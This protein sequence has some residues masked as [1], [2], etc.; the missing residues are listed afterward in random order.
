MPSVQKY[1][2]SGPI[3]HTIP[4]DKAK[5]A[6]K[7]VIVTGGANG[8]GESIVRH[9]VAAGS[10]VTFCDVNAERGCEVEADIN[11][12][13]GPGKAQFVTCDIRSWKSQVALFEKATAGRRRLDIVIANAGISRSS[14][15]SLWKL[16]D[17]NGPP[18]KPDLNIVETNINGTLYS[19]KLATHYF[20]KQPNDEDHDRCFIM[21][22]SMVAYI[23]SP[24][25]WEY[26][27]SKT[28]LLGL[29]RTVRRNSWQQGMRINFVAPCYIRSA[30]RTAEYEK[31]LVDQGV[32]FGEVEDV[33][34][35]MMRIAS[36]RSINGRSIMVVPRAVAQQGYMDVDLDDFDQDGYFKDIQEVQLRIIKDQW[37]DGEALRKYK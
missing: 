15:D 5:L 19:F 36:D 32:R 16:D 6:G 30:I 26:T 3:D 13:G 17:P 35:C 11:A 1:S 4:V 33:A 14:I 12:K 29:M 20:R 28:G 24:G 31:N 2:Y 22:G 10:L 21:T 7:G 34:S 23:N 37:L 18:C 8:I 27:V 9:F 25:N